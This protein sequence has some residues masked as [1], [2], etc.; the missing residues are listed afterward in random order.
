MAISV[1]NTVTLFAYMAL[2]VDFMLQ[3]HRVWERK[4]SRDVSIPGVVVRTF[5]AMVLLAKMFV[6]ADG[7]LIVGQ[8]AM[9]IL[10]IVYL[11]L[12]VKYKNA[13]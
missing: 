4:H 13:S 2:V 1:L 9:V 11:G 5:A 3:I 8:S 10:L 7:V 6:V 12:L